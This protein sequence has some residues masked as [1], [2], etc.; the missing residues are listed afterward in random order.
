MI[1]FI[2]LAFL[3]FSGLVLLLLLRFLVINVDWDQ[4]TMVGFY[5]VDGKE[6][7]EGRC[8]GAFLLTDW[9]LTDYLLE[10]KI[11]I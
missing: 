2:L 6:R 1:F 5:V 3:L 10:E 4:L 9:L 7:G 8:V 11:G